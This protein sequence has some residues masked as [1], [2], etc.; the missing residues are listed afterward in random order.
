MRLTPW[1][2]EASMRLSLFLTIKAVI[3]IISGLA[4]LL[5][6]GAFMGLAGVT[7]DAGG[8]VMARLVGALLVGIAVLCWVARS[9]GPSQGREAALLGL[10][11]GDALGF[12]VV[13]IAQLGGIMTAFGWVFVLLWLLLAAGLGYFRFLV[14]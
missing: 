9:S 1:T 5:L 8:A 3:S 7:L 10:F 14:K 2:K 11:V 13:L 4:L 6:P 12:V